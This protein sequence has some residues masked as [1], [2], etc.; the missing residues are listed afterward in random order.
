MAAC[1]ESKEAYKYIVAYIQ[2]SGYAGQSKSHV[3]L[4]GIG[5]CAIESLVLTGDAKAANAIFGCK[6]ANSQEDFCM[7]GCKL[8][9][10]TF[11][12]I[13]ILLISR[14]LNHIHFDCDVLALLH[15]LPYV[16]CILHLRIRLYGHVI[17]RLTK[18]INALSTAA[19]RVKAYQR[20]SYEV[21]RCRVLRA[22]VKL[23]DNSRTIAYDPT[24][25]AVDNLCQNRFTITH[26]FGMFQW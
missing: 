22:L 16:I 24:G 15:D 3:N 13:H 12:T 19:A 5:T 25:S 9:K 6:A 4:P 1:S 23:D 10:M 7:F 14:Y 21:F 18:N 17:D 26:L 20:L 2:S 11:V 8:H